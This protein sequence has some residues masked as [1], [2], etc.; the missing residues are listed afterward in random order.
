MK[1]VKGCP[2]IICPKCRAQLFKALGKDKKNHTKVNIVD[3]CEVISPQNTDG[4]F[5]IRCSK[6]GEYISIKISAA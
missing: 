5:L 6:C 4:D 3:D 1:K 2:Q